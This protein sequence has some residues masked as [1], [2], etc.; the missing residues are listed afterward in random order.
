MFV[1]ELMVA[2]CIPVLVADRIITVKQKPGGMVAGSDAATFQIVWGSLFSFHWSLNTEWDI[3]IRWHEGQLE[4]EGQPSDVSV[5]LRGTATVNY[6]H[7]ERFAILTSKLTVR[8]SRDG[9]TISLMWRAKE[10]KLWN[11]E[12]AS[13]FTENDVAMKFQNWIDKFH[14][15]MKGIPFKLFVAK[16]ATKAPKGVS[17]WILSLTDL[18]RRG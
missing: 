16:C 11:R 14:R 5:S 7:G 4:F 10:T 6:P 18:I 8:I 3:M 17:T 2:I 1:F 15:S 13:N 9:E 12:E